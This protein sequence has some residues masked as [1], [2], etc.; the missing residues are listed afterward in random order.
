MIENAQRDINIA[1]INEVAMIFHKMGMSIYDVLEA[2]RHQ[3]E[4]PAL[5][6]GPGRRPLHRRRS[7]LSRPRGHGDRPPPG[8]HPGRAA[9]QRCDGRLRRRRV[10][11]LATGGRRRRILVLG[12]TFKENVPDLRN[13]RVI[14]IVQALAARGLHTSTSTTPSPTRPRRSTTTASTWLHP[15]RPVGLR[16][17]IGAVPHARLHHARRDRRWSACWC[18]A[19]WSP[20][21]RACGAR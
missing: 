13:T 21:S 12:L 9:H 18:P 14:D 2:A 16:R 17:V 7:V 1:F 20:T 15:R 8:D 6:A 19:G 4:L 11:R 5:H 10:A 3:V